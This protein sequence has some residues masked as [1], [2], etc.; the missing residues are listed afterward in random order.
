MLVLPVRGKVPSLNVLNSKLMENFP[1]HIQKAYLSLS[2]I[3]AQSQTFR[4]VEVIL[5][6]G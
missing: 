5:G 3:H 4:I 2:I 1:I 6:N